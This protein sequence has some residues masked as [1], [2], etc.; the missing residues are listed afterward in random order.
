MPLWLDLISDP[1]E[2][3][4]SFL[5]EE[6][7][8]VLGV[9]GG[10]VVVFGLPRDP[11]APATGTG[12]KAGVGADARGVTPPSKERTR[13]VI[14]HVGRVVKEGLGGWEWDGVGL[15]VGVGDV[16]LGGDGL[17]VLDEW[18][19]ACAEWGLEFVHVP[20]K[21]EKRGKN[22]FGGKSRLVFP[23]CT[24]YGGC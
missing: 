11:A 4:A 10:L 23:F 24:V 16:D 21:E 20:V 13:E 7:R 14:R 2:W 6:A 19:D 17:E 12:G 8:E 18:E 9:L 22:E 3:A 1:A 5:S 15:A